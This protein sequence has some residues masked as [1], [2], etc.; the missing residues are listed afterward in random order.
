MVEDEVLEE[1]EE[2]EEDVAAQLVSHKQAPASVVAAAKVAREWEV[3][4]E[5][6]RD[7]LLLAPCRRVLVPATLVSQFMAASAEQWDHGYETIGHLLAV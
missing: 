3:R 5:G 6:C 7:P 1:E 4:D 2:E